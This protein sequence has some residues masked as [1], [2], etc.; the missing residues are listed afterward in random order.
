MKV[1]GLDALS[2]TPVLDIK[3]YS[4][5]HDYIE[6]AKAPWWVKHLHDKKER[7]VDE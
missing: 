1:E 6:D 5:K 3:P 7:D 4:S 2:G